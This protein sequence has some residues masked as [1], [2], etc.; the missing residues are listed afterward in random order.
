M[1]KIYLQPQTEVFH[2]RIQ[3]VME[4]ASQMTPG[5]SGSGEYSQ[6]SGLNQ[7]YDNSGGTEFFGKEN[8][9][10]LWED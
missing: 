9:G 10:G 8:N 3:T 4:S 7:T 5:A 6:S 2:V 1:R